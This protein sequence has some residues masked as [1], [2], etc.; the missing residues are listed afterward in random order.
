MK[1]SI[2]LS[3]VD[4]K[5]IS[6]ILETMLSDLNYTIQS[7]TVSVK[8]S[9]GRVTIN[10]VFA[11]VSSPGYNASAMDGIAVNAIDTEEATETNPVRITNYSEI[12]TGNIVVEPYDAVIMIE[13]L[14]ENEDGS[15]T[16]IKSISSYEN[17][18]PIGEDIVLGEL[19]L[20]KHHKIRPIDI[21]ALLSAQIGTIEV[22]RRPKVLIIPTG[23]EITEGIDIVKGKIIDANSYYKK[24]ELELLGIETV[25]SPIQK[26]IYEDL[27]AFILTQVDLFDLVLIGAGSSAGTKDYAKSIIKSNG[28]IYCHGIN[29]KPGKPTI[30]GLINKTPI[31]GM[32]GYP[33]STY[34]AFEAVVRPLISKMC[35]E[36]IKTAAIIKAKV[37]SKVYSSL[38]HHEFVRVRLGKINGEII[39]IPLDR[40]AGVSM[41]LVK[42]DG[43]MIIPKNSE[44]YEPGAYCDVTLLKDIKNIENNLIVIGSHDVMFDVIEN[45]LIDEKITLSSSHVGSYGGIMAI[46]NGQCDIAPVHI[47][48]DDG[49]YNVDLIDIYLDKNYKIIKGV[50]RKQGLFVKKGNPKKIKSLKDLLRNDITFV[51]RQR[52]SGTRILLDHLLSEQHL[53]RK[54]IKGYNLELPSHILIAESV[55]DNRFDVGMGVETVA[56]QYD[57][58]FIKLENEQYDFIVKKDFI[59]TDKYSKF[60]KVIK[61]DAFKNKL[62][63]LGGYGFENIG[64]IIK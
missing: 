14:Q 24:Y 48:L 4:Y 50:S 20:S 15:V 22:V 51:N 59:N 34:M 60:T 25:I 13:D 56:I 23:D 61:S 62:K 6:S 64:E 29:M 3:S 9:I 63:I 8:E 32:P 53:S 5:E 52:G 18:R 36:P 46:R 47:L 10:P 30:I 42:A 19:V 37:V 1:R 38:K 21:S 58:D 16:I 33:V 39:A 57:L 28:K 43:I 54:E 2:Y 7:E 49:V 17:I 31:I 11:N 44:G 40:K 26:D 41:S 35:L 55:K 12:N 27:E 45:L